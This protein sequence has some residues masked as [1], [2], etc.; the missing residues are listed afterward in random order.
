MLLWLLHQKG[1]FDPLYD[2]WG[3]H[4]G[5]D[6]QRIRDIHRHSIGIGH[7]HIHAKKPIKAK[8]HKHDSRYKRSRIHHEHMHNHSERGS[9]YYYYHIMFTR[10]RRST[11]IDMSK[12]LASYN[13]ST[14][15]GGK[16]MTLC[17]TST[18][19]K[20]RVKKD[21]SLSSDLSS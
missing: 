18:Q 21:Q 13:K 12:V 4:F 2:W 8:H 1:F 9:D 3:D 11:N 16:L 19:G 15:T 17:T 14:W 6:D 20:Y 10:T 7:S 5:F